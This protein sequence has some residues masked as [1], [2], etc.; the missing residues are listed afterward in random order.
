MTIG[1]GILLIVLGLIFAFDAIHLH[2]TA[3]DGQ[4]LGWILVFGGIL[5]IAIPLIIEQQRRRRVVVEDRPVAR[6][7]RVVEDRVIDDPPL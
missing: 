6:R 5:A 1:F 3:L 4:T 2:T 7:S